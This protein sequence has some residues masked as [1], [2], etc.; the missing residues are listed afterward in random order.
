MTLKERETSK[1]S[2]AE[3]AE[4]HYRNLKKYYIEH[5]EDKIMYCKEKCHIIRNAKVLQ[6]NLWQT[7]HTQNF[8]K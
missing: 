8:D 3:I 2:Y 4:I 1:K 6:E 5:R 7:S